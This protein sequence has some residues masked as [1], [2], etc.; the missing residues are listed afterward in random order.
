MRDENGR[1]IDLVEFVKA[2][3]NEHIEASRSGD[4]LIKGMD[5]KYMREVMDGASG[6]I[7]RC[8]GA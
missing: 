6:R 5:F 8:L 3:V 2:R 1:P 4:V 7:C